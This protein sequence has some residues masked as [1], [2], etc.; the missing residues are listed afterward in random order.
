MVGP[1]NN[2]DLITKINTIDYCS[3][4][5]SSFILGVLKVSDAARVNHGLARG[6][7]ILNFTPLDCPKTHLKSGN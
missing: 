1:P 2:H 4:V 3:A 7:K 6:E 5:G